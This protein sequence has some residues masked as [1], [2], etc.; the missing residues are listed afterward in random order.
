[1]VLRNLTAMAIYDQTF[2]YSSDD[3][4]AGMVVS[5]ECLTGLFLLVAV[6][7]GCFRIAAL[8]SPFGI[9]M[10]N[11]NCAQLMACINSG[12]FST[13][14]VLLN[15]KPVLS[16]SYLF[17][18]FSIFL[19]PVI[20]ISFLLMSFNRF[21]ACFFPLRYQNLFSSSMIRTFIVFNWLL[22]LVAGSYLVVVRECNFVFYHFG[23]LFAGSVSVKCGTLLSLYSISIQ[24][25][26]SITIVGLDVVTLVALMAFR[27]KV[28]QS[29]SV[30]VRRREL[31]FS[32]QV[33]IQGAVFLCHGAWYDMGHAIL[34]GN[35][36]RWKFFFTTSFSSNLLHVFDPVVVFAFNKEFRRWLFRNFNVPTAQKRIVTVVSAHNT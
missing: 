11:Q 21:C 1:M 10:I 25:V 6:I 31:S 26:L 4:L 13:L 23:W 34:P 30:E 9:L 19:L 17:G 20:L 33:I 14:G 2:V 5:M 24:T 18:N 12:S 16:I 29:H 35:D 32:G 8:K 3:A 7:I 27:S 36:D 28:Y 15:I 22:S